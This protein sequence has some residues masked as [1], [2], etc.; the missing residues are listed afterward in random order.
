MW[1]RYLGYVKNYTNILFTCY[2]F[3]VM[4]MQRLGR[5]NQRDYYMAY[6]RKAVGKYKVIVLKFLFPKF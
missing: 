5:K 3:E 4:Q 2:P 6:Y 1:R